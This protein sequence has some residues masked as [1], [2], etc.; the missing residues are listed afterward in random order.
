MYAQPV[1]SVSRA[2]SIIR[3]LVVYALPCLLVWSFYFLAFYPGMMSQDSIDQW[4][5]VVTAK[6]G[7]WH[8]ASLSYLYWLLSRIW[9]SPAIVCITQ[10][11]G[12]AAV[13]AYGMVQLEKKGLPVWG[14]VL[15]VLFFSLFPLNGYY[16]NTLFKDIPFSIV[17]LL[18][19][20]YL[21]EIVDSGGTWLR[22]IKNIVGLGLALSFLW[23]I[24][25]NGIL[26]VLTTIVGLLI[27]YPRYFKKIGLLA[28]LTIFLAFLVK[29]P[30]YKALHVQGRF[31][32]IEMIMTHQIG[33]VINSGASL[34]PAEKAFLQ[35]VQPMEIW[36]QNYNP[37]LID[38]LIFNPHF[39]Q[40]YSFLYPDSV[41]KEFIKVWF[42]IV[43]RNIPV[44][45]KHQA[46]VT[47]LVWDIG[48]QQDSYNYS[49]HP[50]IDPNDLGLKTQSFLPGFKNLLVHFP[51]YVYRHKFLFALTLRPATYVY[52][53][54]ILLGLIFWFT[55]KKEIV[56]LALPFITLVFGVF[57]TIPAQHV[58]YLYPCFLLTP[59]F[60][61]YLVIILKKQQQSNMLFN[62]PAKQSA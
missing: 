17:Y 24:R 51:N 34:K 57:I 32:G 62:T 18:I 56:L 16:V 21:L 43:K 1:N 12:M 3:P 8:P 60:A 14:S 37:F 52:A 50:L 26:T 33:A 11:L 22:K 36:Q 49:V 9:F 58:R 10:M 61:A 53:G 47:D 5:P 45:L 59:F 2:Q 46:K 29:G 27:F 55:R 6:Y 28:V 31:Y 7:D 30:L 44:L 48:L 23:V 54:F 41:Q 38:P 13:F 19:F 25:H 15:M 35:Q 40:Y 42:G 20:V 4:R 39:Q